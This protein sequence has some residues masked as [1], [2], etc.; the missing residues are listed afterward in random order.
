[1]SEIKNKIS[2][3]LR[4]SQ[5]VIGR[6]IETEKINLILEKILKK[7]NGSQGFDQEF[8]YILNNFENFK[9]FFNYIEIYKISRMKDENRIL[10]Y[11]NFRYKFNKASNQKK[12]FDYPPYLLIEPNAA[13]NL[14]CP[15]CFQIDKTFTRKPFMGI[16]KWDLFT[17]IV[18]EANEIGVGA[19]TLASRGEPLMHPKISDMLN[20]ISKKENIFELKLNSNA[21]FLTE[22]LCHDIFKS[23]VTTFVISADHYEKKT[24]EELRKNSNFEKIV[25]N[26]KMLYGIRNEFYKDCETEIR[27]S[28]VDFYKNLD[29]KKFE[30]FWS[31]ISD[32]VSSSDAFERWD[33]YN[34][35]KDENA[36]SPC[37]YLWDRMYVWHDGKCNPCDAD[38]KS[39]LSYGN[40]SNL[41]IK[42]VWNGEAL[43]KHRE[44]HSAK[45][46]MNL[47]PCDRC[48]IEFN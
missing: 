13:C 27:I 36:K 15:M 45:K 26:V 9:K 16:M 29:K 12:V 37:S 7:I 34:N 48:G 30:E 8:L 20:Y 32:N 46:R 17:K 40:V 28:G 10:K 25:N 35:K 22:K 18:D 23:K 33:T 1:M 11:L 14:R 42:E 39:Y 3:Y 41:S 47:I 5:D 38:Y 31:P 6:N 24:F 21:S 4:V 2:P 19:I 43:K 44:I